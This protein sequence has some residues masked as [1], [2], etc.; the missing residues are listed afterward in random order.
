MP[1][2]MLT[3]GSTLPD[4]PQNNVLLALSWSL[5]ASQVDIE[6]RP[7]HVDKELWNNV[8]RLVA[9]LS[10]RAIKTIAVEII[11]FTE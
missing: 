6:N 1:I 4:L 11:F 7:S 3:S 5:L 9:K 2:Q 8:A 10:Y